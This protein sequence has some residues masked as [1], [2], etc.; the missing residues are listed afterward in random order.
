MPIVLSMTSVFTPRAADIVVPFLKSKCKIHKGD[1]NHT[2]FEL[3]NAQW[4]EFSELT[5]AVDIF[6]KSAK[7]LPRMLMMGLFASLDFHLLAIYRSRSKE[8]IGPGRNSDPSY[9]PRS[10]ELLDLIFRDCRATLKSSR[11]TWHPR[12]T[13]CSP[14][15][16][17]R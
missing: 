2:I 10:P 6:Q 3:S 11:P 8:R 12:S 5:E 14:R 4:V 16:A 15:R 9:F 17:V 1:E 7:E 13:S